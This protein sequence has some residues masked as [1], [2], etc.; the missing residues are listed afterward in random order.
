MSIRRL[1]C[2]AVSVA[3]VMTTGVEA[4]P[5]DTAAAVADP[6]RRKLDCECDWGW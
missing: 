5:D 1:A 3:C 6:A 2:A 4:E